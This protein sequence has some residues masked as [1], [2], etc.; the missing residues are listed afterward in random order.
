MAVNFALGR[1]IFCY[2]WL[3]LNDI[4]RFKTACEHKVIDF[5]KRTGKIIIV[6]SSQKNLAQI[7]R[8]YIDF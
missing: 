5:L 2:P 3:N 8:S 7:L 6:P 4:E 1:D